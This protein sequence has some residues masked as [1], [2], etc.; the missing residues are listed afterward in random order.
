MALVG[1]SVTVQ[2]VQGFTI[3]ATGE[4]LAWDLFQ[5]IVAAKKQAAF[6][7]LYQAEKQNIE[8]IQKLAEKKQMKQEEADERIDQI[9]SVFR[10]ARIDA[11]QSWAQDATI[12]GAT[13]VTYLQAHAEVPLAGVAA[14]VAAA[15]SLGS[16]P[17]PND[18][19]AP[20]VG[21]AAPVALPVT[22]EAG[23]VVL[24]LT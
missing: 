12:Y 5:A 15:Q 4:G 1:G 8:S 19:G 9:A 7:G 10:S 11:A 22:G 17:T 3:N 16:T 20:L 6:G 18:P 14:T 24:K 21:P 2:S 23:A 13:I